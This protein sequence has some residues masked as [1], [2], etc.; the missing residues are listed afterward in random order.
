MQQG[1]CPDLP[2]TTL[3]QSLRVD[4]KQF[5]SQLWPERPRVA[6]EAIRGGNRVLSNRIYKVATVVSA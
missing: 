5:V 3:D 2:Y 6:L 1:R 4:N